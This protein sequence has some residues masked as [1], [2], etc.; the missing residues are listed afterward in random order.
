MVLLARPS[1]F[2][3]PWM[4]AILANGTTKKSVVFTY[5]Y[6][7]CRTNSSIYSHGRRCWMSSLP[8]KRNGDNPTVK[9]TFPWYEEK[10][11][12]SEAPGSP[13]LSLFYDPYPFLVA[14]D[15]TVPVHAHSLTFSLISSLEPY[16]CRLACYWSYDT[17]GRHDAGDASCR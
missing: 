3:W 7:S 5:L 17:N 4:N 6:W 9:E 16:D 15:L 11:G 2:V 8:G 14:Y 12:Y 10:R 13:A 1:S